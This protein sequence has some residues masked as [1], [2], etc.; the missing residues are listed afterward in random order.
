MYADKV[1]FPGLHEFLSDQAGIC[2]KIF[3]VGGSIRDAQLGLNTT[4]LDFV[5]FH[6]APAI[7]KRTADAFQGAF[8]LLDA[9]RNTARTIID[10]GQIRYILDFAEV[11]GASIED[12]LATRD[13]TINAMAVDLTEPDKLVDPLGGR[14]DL[15]AKV[16]RPCR[17]DAFRQDSIRTLRAVRFI[18]RF[19]LQ[20]EESTTELI[21]ASSKDICNSSPERIRDELF[22]ILEST[23]IKVVLELLRS[24]GLFDTLF[25][26]LK[27]LSAIHPGT[28]HHHDVLTHT[29]R[30]AEFIQMLLASLRE[31]QY[32]GSNQWI[33]GACKE[34]APYSHSLIN[35]SKANL[36]PPRTKLGLL[37]LAVLYHDCG[38]EVESVG[39][40]ITD[41]SDRS[42]HASLGAEIFKTVSK[43]FALSIVEADYVLRIIQNHMREELKTTAQLTDYAFNIYTFF[44][45]AGP[46]GVLI[47]IMHLA[48]LLATYEQDLAKERWQ[49]AL[50]SAVRLLEGWFRRHNEWVSPSLPVNGDDLIQEFNLQPGRHIGEALEAIRQAQV[51]GKVADRFGAL[52]FAAQYLKEG[53]HG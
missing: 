43:K 6:A 53:N 12:D 45:A 33:G 40:E 8:Y 9:E 30:V 44:K 22:T 47:V 7:A 14:Q 49:I 5:V 46:A 34:L 23:E 19:D 31:E 37:Y 16:L 24:F 52:E 10:R 11:R 18:N 2:E 1:L 15:E 50:Q 21:R 17:L 3:L 32:S 13:F 48:D 25:P 28:P 51:R 36:T 26:E 20:Y 27:S 42:R 39:R 4:D 35:E 38:K 41:I 29:F